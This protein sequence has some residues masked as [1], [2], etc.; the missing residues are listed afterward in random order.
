MYTRNVKSQLAAASTAS[1]SAQTIMT[2][3]TGN[4]FVGGEGAVSISNITNDFLCA[5]GDAN[6]TM[7]NKGDNSK[8][9]G[10]SAGNY[11]INVS[12]NTWIQGSDD[13]DVVFSIGP[14]CE[15][16][17][18]GGNDRIS[19][20]GSTTK[21]D[22]GEGDDIVTGVVSGLRYADLKKLDVIALMNRIL[23]SSIPN[24]DL[25]EIEE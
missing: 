14:D 21:V 8:I 7:I 24:L 18:L 22:A 4:M 25:E 19:A 5:G 17:T 1:M 13:T 3:G 6:I 2:N 16:N 11:I 23:A 15:V 12:S 10:G 9:Q 20:D